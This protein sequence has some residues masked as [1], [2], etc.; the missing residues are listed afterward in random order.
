MGTTPILAFPYPDPT[1]PL[2]AGANKIRDGL[3]AVE[4]RLTVGGYTAA[5]P[6]VRQSAAT[7]AGP[8]SLWV[9][10]DFGVATAGASGDTAGHFRVREGYCD[11]AALA[12]QNGNGPS[13]PPAAAANTWVKL[14][15]V[16]E[17]AHRM[18]VGDYSY[19]SFDRTAPGAQC[20]QLLLDKFFIAGEQWAMLDRRINSNNQWSLAVNWHY[21]VDVV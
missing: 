19:W 20:G 14:P 6:I 16:T 13:F 1:D 3:L 21:P 15:A 7:L 18:P 9:L 5:D 8:G 17:M 4:T 12:V 10:G 11:G 2:S